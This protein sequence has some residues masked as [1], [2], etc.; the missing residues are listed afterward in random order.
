VC[1]MCQWFSSIGQM[2]PSDKT[3]H[4]VNGFKILGGTILDLSVLQNSIT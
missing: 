4:L 1:L 3:D 2:S